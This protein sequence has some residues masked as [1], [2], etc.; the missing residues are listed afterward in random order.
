M[1]FT[2]FCASLLSSADPQLKDIPT[3]RL[4]EVSDAL[5]YFYWSNRI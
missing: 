2:K 5:I 1:G 3:Q 4:K